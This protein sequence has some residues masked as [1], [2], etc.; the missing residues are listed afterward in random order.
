MTYLA[1]WWYNSNWHSTIGVTPYEV[2]YGQPPS[3]HIPYVAGDSSMEAIDRSLKA[4]GE[5]IEMLKYYLQRAQQ[6]MKKQADKHRSEKQWEVGAWVYVKLQP[7][8][9]HSLALRR[10]QKLGPKF[11]GPFPVIACIGAVAYRLQLPIHA[12]IH[13]VFHISSLNEHIGAT[14]TSLGAVSDMDDA[15]LIAAELVAV[16]ARKLGK[17]GNKAVI[18]L[19]I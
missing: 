8:R 2:V 13:P 1:E 16:L 14:P 19:L 17:K 15:G 6:R 3:L 18:Y 7:Y 5:C 9:H 4:R 11:F 12:K 10:N